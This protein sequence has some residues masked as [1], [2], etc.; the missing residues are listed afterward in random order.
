MPE[1]P[2]PRVVD[3]WRHREAL[4]YSGM[5][6]DRAWPS[7]LYRGCPSGGAVYPLG[8]WAMGTPHQPNIEYAD[9]SSDDWAIIYNDVL[10][11]KR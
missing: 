4:N 2:A 5:T 7:E 6:D 11:A 10:G 8:W 3:A 1:Y 9:V